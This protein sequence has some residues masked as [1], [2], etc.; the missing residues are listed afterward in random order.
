MKKISHLICHFAVLILL[1]ACAGFYNP[2][3]D[4]H[5]HRVW[6]QYIAASP[7]SYDTPYSEVMFSRLVADMRAIPLEGAH[8][9]VRRHVESTILWCEKFP[10]YHRRAQA[11][12]HASKKYSTSATRVGGRAGYYMSSDGTSMDRIFGTA[13]G[14][15]IG[16]SLNESYSRHQ[17]A[18][19]MRPHADIG[20]G[21]ILDEFSLNNRLGHAST[22]YLRDTAASMGRVGGA[23]F[24][25]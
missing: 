24:T 4:Q 2:A 23:F 9:D 7:F 14:A 25:N 5:T 17:A 15:M 21:L 8:P 20:R 13:V 16:W 3:Y 18:L 1:A 12:Y 11:A 6:R 19:I 10:S 22:Y